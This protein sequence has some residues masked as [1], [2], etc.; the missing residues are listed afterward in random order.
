MFPSCEPRFF[1]RSAPYSSLYC[2][3]GDPTGYACTTYR[4]SYPEGL[5]PAP[6]PSKRC[7]SIGE[8]DLMRNKTSGF[9]YLLEC[10]QMSLEDFELARLDRAARLRKQ[11]REIAEQWIEAAVEAQ[12]AQWVRVNRRTA[13]RRDPED[14]QTHTRHSLSASSAAI[15]TD[16]AC[17][18]TSGTP[19]GRCRAVEPKCAALTATLPAPVPISVRPRSPR[20]AARVELAPGSRDR[21]APQLEKSR[22][23]REEPDTRPDAFAAVRHFRR[24]PYP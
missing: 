10:S 11:M 17:P 8:P 3:P 14:T 19:L 15:D 2:R 9:Q 23:P 22:L 5:S 12:L 18:K 20:A 21:P 6:N 1:L 13:D 4:L 7:G 16:L 24:S